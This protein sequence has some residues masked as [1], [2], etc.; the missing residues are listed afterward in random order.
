MSNLPEAEAILQTLKREHPRIH[1]DADTPARLRRNIESDAL[2]KRWWAQAQTDAEAMVNE[3]P[4]TYDIPDGKRLLSTSRRAL[5]RVQTLGVTWMVTGDDRY[6]DRA[7]RELEAVAGFKDWNP[8]HFLD[9]AE[10]AYAV[11]LGYDWFYDRWTQ[12]QRRILRQALKRHALDIAA[13]AYRGKGPHRHKWWT[14]ATHNWNQ[15]CNGGVTAGALAIAEDE[16]ELAG[17]IVRSAAERLPQALEHYS[18]DGAWFVGPVYWGYATKYTVVV[19]DAMRTALGTDFGLSEIDGLAEAGLM[20]IHCAGPTDELYNFG[21]ARAGRSA[22]AEMLW[23]ARRYERPAYGGWLRDRAE[24]A[25]SPERCLQWAD[26]PGEPDDVQALPLYRHFRVAEVFTARSAWDDPNA[27]FVGIKGG[28]AAIQHANLDCG[29]FI[30]DVDGVRWAIDLGKDNYNLPEY[31]GSRRW[32]YYRM[33]AEGHNTLLINPDAEADQDPGAKT[34]FTDTS[35]EGGAVRA[36]VDLSS[37]YRKHGAQ[38]V[39]RTAELKGKALTITD[40]VELASP[41]EIWWLLHTRAEIDLAADGRS[42]VL[43]QDGQ[44]V[45]VSL[46]TAPNDARFEVMDASPLPGSPDP[47]GQNPNTGAELLNGAEGDTVRV[48][49]TPQWGEPNPDEAIH[50]LAIHLKQVRAAEIVVAMGPGQ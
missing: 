47:E 44:R 2:A 48:G 20:S 14:Q 4:S 3:A 10:M 1:V 31:F 35:A 7:W 38:S 39:Q 15:V 23:L 42:A 32:E 17:F 8:T 27:A 13:D 50:K 43:R 22:P 6:A 12:D 16:P 41:G 46:E 25:G 26:A 21:D 29:S 28:H 37:A 24:W 11:G 19:L 5:Q 49:Q 30:Y 40:E 33:R 36:S 9:T 34:A 18:P 45:K